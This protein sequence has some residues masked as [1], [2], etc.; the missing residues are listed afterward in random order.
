MADAKDT[1]KLLT[2]MMSPEKEKMNEAGDYALKKYYE[3]LEGQKTLLMAQHEAG[4]ISEQEFQDKILAIQKKTI[5]E[6]LEKQVESAQKYQQVTTAAANFASGGYASP[7]SRGALVESFR[8]TSAGQGGNDPELKQ[9]VQELHKLLK[10]GIQ[11]TIP[12]YGT[13]GLSD[14]MD[15]ITRFNA[16]I[17]KK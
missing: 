15:D 3:T 16:K 10:A 13:N 11:A 6:K 9:L 12:R 17:Y 14:A 8:A 1:N 5:D 7:P 2:E 4:L